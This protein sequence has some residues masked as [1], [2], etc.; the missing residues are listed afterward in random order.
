[1]NGPPEVLRPT[2]DSARK[3]CPSC[4]TLNVPSMKFCGECGTALG[5]NHSTGRRPLPYQARQPPNAASASGLSFSRTS[6]ASLSPPSRGDAEDTRELLSRPFRNESPSDRAL[7]RDSR[8]VIGDAVMAVGGHADNDR[9]RR[10]AC[11]VRSARPGRCRV[12]A[13]RPGRRTGASR[14]CRCPH[15]VEKPQ[16]RSAPKDRAW[17]PATSST[18]RRACSR[19]PSPGSGLVGESTRRSTR[20][21][22]YEEAARSSSRERRGLHRSRR[23]QRVI[24]G[25]RGSLQVAGGSR[26]RS[27]AAIPRELRQIKDL[28]HT[29]AEERKVHLVSVTGIAGI[30]KSRLSWEFDKYFDEIGRGRPCTGI[31]GVAFPTARA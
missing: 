17:S 29:S 23:A 7:R 1:M 12:R 16:S 4:G 8:E 5:G 25:L 6:S 22:V 28:F 20:A 14:P 30:G 26:R 31:A 3:A 9:G 19:P 2:W 18:P 21:I 10:R 24:S 27:S 15:L 11:W 13:G